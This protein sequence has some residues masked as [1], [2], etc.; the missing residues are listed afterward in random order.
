MKKIVLIILLL[1][2]TFANQPISAQV[3]KPLGKISRIQTSSVRY[4]SLAAYSDGNGVWLEW[5]TDVETKNLGF[6]VYRL[7]DGN[8][9][10]ISPALISGAYLQARE[11]KI[12]SGNYSFFDP[13]GDSSS[14][15]IIE[16]VDAYERRSDSRQIRT[17]FVDRLETVTGI[18]S[19]R[20]SEQ[21]R[22][23]KPEILRNESILPRD[24]AAE[25]E[26]NSQSSDLQTQRW[27]AAQN[28]V[29]IAVKNE[30]IYRVSKAELQAA[31]FDVQAPTERWQLYVNGIEQAI[32]TGN[33]GEYVEF[34]GKGID[35]PEADTNI[36]FL[37]VGTQNG[38]RIGTTTIRRFA[39][40]VVSENY[41]Q[42]FYKKERQSYSSG[43]LNG[44]TENFFG[45]VIIG[46]GRTINFNLSGVDYTSPVS[47]IDVAIQG[48]TLI[49]HQVRVILNGVELGTMTGENYDSIPKH[50]DFPTSAL[51]E[52]SNAIQFIPLNGS[53]D[54]TVF[55]SIKV[56]FARRYR[57]EQNRLSFYVPNY[58]ASFVD[59]F[60]SPNVRVFDTTNP[61]AP[62]LINS[63]T[64]E[65][66]GGTYRVNL[67]SN[68]GRVLYAV[69]DSAILQAA[70]I[71]RN[72]PSTLST[73]ANTGE[74]IIVSYKDWLAQAEDWANYRRAQGM[75]VKVVNVEDIFDEFNYGVSKAD[76]IK[77]F[78]NYAENNWQTA[79]NYVLLLGDASY[80]PK[81]Y[82]GN[83][84]N[85]FVPTRL[86]DTV[87]TETG[88]DDA[89]ADFNNDGLAE[90]AVGRIPAR[91]AATVTLAL[92]KVTN[93]EQNIAT[94]GLSRGA[95]F[96][97]D[98]PNGYDF[99]GLSNRLRDQLPSD[100]PRIMINRALPDAPTQL[101]NQINSGKFL[102]NYSGHG[103]VG[104]WAGN[105]F[106]N[107]TNAEQLTNANKWSIFTML[108]CLNGY[109]IQPTDS[110]SEILL[111]NPNGGAVA[112]WSSTGLTTPDIQEVMA[113]RFYNQIGARNI[114]RL[115]DLV[116]DAKTTIN[117]GR[118]VRLSWVLLGDPTL[119]VK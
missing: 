80:D 51:L 82:T 81:N 72:T 7:V 94:Q 118:D 109:F 119:K 55:D 74:L 95:I 5:K 103:N 106:F 2:F 97:S 46:A 35:T 93:F 40:S 47:S 43:Y 8:K 23:F 70:S 33:N 48:S 45:S 41:A 14:V 36:Y 21:A 111:K 85:N 58:K 25:V 115:G 3:T 61:S 104:V 39:S 105:G 18:S 53:S 64:I 114:G 54:I 28:G 44:D 59:G 98:S 116:N 15:Y 1:T 84:F 112:T 52:N 66:N 99:E 50:F 101:I 83:G 57:A 26:A 6:F 67:P 87:Y 30:G 79:P 86:V 60:S 102:V 4:A 56:N 113:T 29:K 22:N 27:V 34:Y 11:E 92:N 49:P 65:Q 71:V 96:A 19:E 24:L 9:E 37:I 63:L 76:A 100:I 69:E 117:F 62:I 31:G 20:L 77:D 68:R 107:N 89:L 75:S 32:S 90:I 110:M 88:S 10:S 78:L 16:S 91:N 13:N 17:E 73:A 12:T 42:S 38:R 108:T